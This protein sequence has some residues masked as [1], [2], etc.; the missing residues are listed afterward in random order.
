M[1]MTN[2]RETPN[3]RALMLG[4]L[5][6]Q[7]RRAKSWSQAQLAAQ[8]GLSQ[9]KISRIERAKYQ[10]PPSDEIIRQLAEALGIDPRLLLRAAGRAWM[11]NHGRTRSSTNSKRLVTNTRPYG[12]DKMSRPRSS[13][14]TRKPWLTW[15]RPSSSSYEL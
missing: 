7:H 13:Q 2:A 15:S 8:T 4:A 14:D 9:D 5:V 6:A 3:E 1:R 12:A 11:V 10:R